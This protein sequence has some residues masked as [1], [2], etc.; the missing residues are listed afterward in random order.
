MRVLTQAKVVGQGTWGL[1]AIL[2]LKIVEWSASLVAHGFPVRRNPLYFQKSQICKGVP[3]L[4]KPL[5]FRMRLL[6]ATLGALII[7]AGE[8]AKAEDGALTS[9]QIRTLVEKMKLIEG[10]ACKRDQSSISC[11]GERDK[12]KKCLA[13]KDEI[14]S[15]SDDIVLSPVVEVPEYDPA[16]FSKY[17]PAQ[18]PGLNFNE[19]NDFFN[20]SEVP[21]ISNSEIRLY[22]ADFFSNSEK[23]SIKTGD[24]S[25]F[26]KGTHPSLVVFGRHYMPMVPV[27]LLKEGEAHRAEED[28]RGKSSSRFSFL[29]EKGCDFQ[30]FEGAY[31]TENYAPQYSKLA[32]DVEFDYV[33]IIKIDMGYYVA[34]YTKEYYIRDHKKEN[35]SKAL[36]L[37]PL[38]ISG[39]FKTD[40]YP[41]CTFVD[42]GNL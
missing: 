36:H 39:T 41:S 12:A 11:Q 30:S 21:Q 13:L 6:A 15:K 27:Y 22:Q 19:S 5:G 35:E 18:C 23:R 37:H 8:V 7:V 32:W 2:W 34:D 20:G 26:L 3:V 16:V 17:A 14:L 28:F 9:E 40:A 4:R 33:S 29:D 38:K 10:G 31:Q 42:E 24:S 25:M 1:R